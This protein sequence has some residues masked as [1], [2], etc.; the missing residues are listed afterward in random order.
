MIWPALVTA[1]SKPESVMRVKQVLDA[2]ELHGVSP[3]WA[4]ERRLA[5]LLNR[6]LTLMEMVDEICELEGT[7]EATDYLL[8]DANI[9]LR[10]QLFSTEREMKMMKNYQ[11]PPKAGSIT[12]DMVVRAKE[13]PIEQLVEFDK[14]KAKAW[15][16]QDKSP[17]LS[18]HRKANRAHCFPC[19]KSFNPIDVLMDRDG[20][21]FPEAVRF[22]CR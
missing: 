20:M 9:R 1:Y 5:Y 12:N 15:C 11:E 3:A 21:S 6:K 13:Y 14:G 8:V 2:A 7:D 19:N 17:S 10:V 22:L 4:I 16:H 18:W